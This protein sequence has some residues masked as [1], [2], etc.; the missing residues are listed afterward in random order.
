[1]FESKGVRWGYWFLIGNSRLSEEDRFSLVE[2][3][4]SMYLSDTGRKKVKGDDYEGVLTTKGQYDMLGAFGGQ[5]FEAELDSS[6]GKIKLRFLINEGGP[7]QQ[8]LTKN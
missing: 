1:M 5:R 7:S 2:D 6:T 8:D 3:A 4:I